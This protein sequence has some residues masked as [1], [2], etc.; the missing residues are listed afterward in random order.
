MV[1]AAAPLV[2]RLVR[3]TGKFSKAS[4]ENAVKILEGEI[5]ALSIHR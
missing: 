5:H 2:K 1:L 3:G 4:F